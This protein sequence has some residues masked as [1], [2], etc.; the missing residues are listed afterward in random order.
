M[1]LSF[2]P[3]EPA[4]L[5]L[6]PALLLCLPFV[7][8]L[9]AAGASE[10]DLGA[11]LVVEIELER[12]ERHPLAL[13]RSR[14]LV[15]LPAVQQELARPLGRMIEAAALQIFR[16]VRVDEPDL[17]AARIGIG[18]GDRR[19]A[20][21]QRLHLGPGEGDARLAGLRSDEHTSE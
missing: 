12:D 13:D 10:L 2:C 6:P 9:L 19:L 21:A 15:D 18:L 20:L 4:T 7:V 17:P 1:P 5:A 16:N 11:P 8:E 3:H 14:Q